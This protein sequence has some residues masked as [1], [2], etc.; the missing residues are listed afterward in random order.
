MVNEA[1]EQGRGEL[2]AAKDLDPFAESQVG[3]HDGGLALVAIRK[4]VE[5]QF[6]ALLVERNE[7]QLIEDQEVDFLIAALK[8][9]QCKL[10]TGLSE[11]PHYVGRPLERNPVLTLGS[12]HAQRD[13]QHGLPGSDR[14][15]QDYV[16][17]RVDKAAG[18]QLLNDGTGHAMQLLPFD[19]LQRLEVGKTRFTNAPLRYAVFSKQRLFFE[20]S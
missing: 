5:Q 7:A 20:L 16:L 4:Q 1:V 8:A 19:H 17:T 15:R 9:T 3:R 11:F 18:C 6:S 10:A 14:P 2:L 12:L 13:S